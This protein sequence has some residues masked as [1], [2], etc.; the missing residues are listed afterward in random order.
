MSIL[1]HGHNHAINVY[2]NL[3]TSSSCCYSIISILRS[4]HSHCRERFPHTSSTTSSFN[5]HTVFSTHP[6]SSQSPSLS[7][8]SKPY[9]SSQQ[10][11]SHFTFHARTQFILSHRYVRF[12]F[13]SAP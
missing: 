2:C 6:S 3:Y 9:C 8:L 13:H 7:Y 10:T 5:S 11:R 4:Q 12:G 1:L